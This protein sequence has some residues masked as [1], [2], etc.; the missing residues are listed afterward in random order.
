MHDAIAAARRLTHA[1]TGV[2]VE[3]VAVIAGFA[4]LD[5]A[6]TANRLRLGAGGQPGKCGKTKAEQGDAHHGQSVPKGDAW[7]KVPRSFKHAGLRLKLSRRSYRGN[8]S[9]T[10]T[11]E[12][13]CASSL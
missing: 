4:G 3:F 1:G 13:S 8:L 12:P 5:F 10:S 6:V 2:G 9:A 11:M 7:V